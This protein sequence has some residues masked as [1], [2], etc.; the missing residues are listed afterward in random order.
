MKLEVA[1]ELAAI[2]IAPP[3]IVPSTVMP[4]VALAWPDNN[5]W[6]AVALRVTLPSVQVLPPEL[7]AIARICAP[8]AI[9]M[10]GASSSTLNAFAVEWPDP[11]RRRVSITASALRLM[12][13]S[14]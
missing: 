9:V 4:V 6:L 3:V 10:V 2:V 12:E 11:S 1:V 8:C 13:L 7:T 5:D 14:A